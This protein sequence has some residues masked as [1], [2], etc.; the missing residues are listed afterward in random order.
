MRD[1]FHA[2][3]KWQRIVIRV[4]AVILIVLLA[5]SGTIFAVRSHGRTELCNTVLQNKED[6]GD[7]SFAASDITYDGE[8]YA[9]RKNIF[10]FLMLGI[11]KWETVSKAA[12]GISGGQS[13]AMFLVVVDTEQRKISV[14]AIPRNTMAIVD[15]Y[16]KD[17][18]F[19]Y[20][21]Y[22]QITL[23]HGYGDG[24][25]QSCERTANVVSRLFYHIPIN[26]YCS[27][28]MGAIGSINDA[29]G[30][31]EITSLDNFYLPDF[32]LQA[33]DTIRLRGIEAYYYL[34]YR[35]TSIF[36]TATRRL[37][38]QQQYLSVFTKQALEQTKKDITFPVK[39]Y[40]TIKPF[41]V[42]DFDMSEI[43]YLA[44]EIANYDVE[45]LSVPGQTIIGKKGYEEFYIDTDA[46]L[47]MILPVF[48]EKTCSS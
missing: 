34:K 46:F 41:V 17:G 22:G 44:S 9:Y 39:L 43:L 13:D 21:G 16:G 3:K 40:N 23:Q 31:V 29:V 14:I 1:K 36:N 25:E 6:I 30:G 15:V 27:V 37:E 33:G 35:D 19:R 10:T 48:C 42:T 26:G 11:D 2:L 4:V 47:Q 20:Q 45:I 7:L 12:D 24:M 8:S 28:N 18:N 5:L 32:G 38:R